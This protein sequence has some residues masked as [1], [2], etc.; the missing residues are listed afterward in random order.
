MKRSLPI[1]SSL[2]VLAL[3]ALALTATAQGTLLG[4]EDFHYLLHTSE[5]GGPCASGPFHSSVEQGTLELRA[6]ATWSAVGLETIVCPDGSQSVSSIP[7]GG[8]YA[9]GPDGTLTLTVD[10]GEVL[11]FAL[12]FDHGLISNRAGSTPV[13]ALLLAVPEASAAPAVAGS[14]TVGRFL[15]THGPAGLTVTAELG[16][17]VVSAGGSWSESGVRH[18][19]TPSGT[20]DAPYAKSGTLA[21]AADGALTVQ[22]GARP[23]AASPDGELLFWAEDQGAD[24]GV[25]IAVRQG[26][27]HATAGLDGAWKLISAG[28]D[29]GP[30]AG[31]PLTWGFG[32]DGSADGSTGA[33]ALSGS[34]AELSSAGPGSFT[35]AETG[36]LTTDP[37]GVLSFAGAGAVMS[38]GLAQGERYGVLVDTSP[39]KAELIL[40]WRTCVAP[41]AYGSG[42]PGAGGITPTLGSTGGLPTAGS[43]AFALRVE[44]GT[45]GAAGLAVVTGQPA[46]GLPF[47]GG[48]LWIAGA[49]LVVLPLVLSGPTG[50]PGSGSADLPLPIPAGPALVG[51]DF[52]AQ[53]FVLDGAAL[54][55]LALTAGLAFEVCE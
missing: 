6:D 39:G 4:D 19:L 8:T 48:T 23:G 32:A 26:G 3:L 49:P 1:P 20:S 40:L 13:P 21:V 44:Q 46:P 15:H 14:F 25:T 11:T 24:A 29:Q 45:G 36:L 28:T 31:L 50:V 42:A 16:T 30:T 52:H 55:G 7:T 38:G 51:A 33:I 22:P 27:T 35:I 43:A 2:P 37:A 17:L 9:L 18:V 47:A 12:R 41:L 10:A 34:G 5:D 53:A 54:G